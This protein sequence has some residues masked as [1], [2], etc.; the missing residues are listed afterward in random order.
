MLMKTTSF[1]LTSLSVSHLEWNHE[2]SAAHGHRKIG[3][4]HCRVRHFY[5][6][7]VLVPRASESTRVDRFWKKMYSKWNESNQCPLQTA[8][9]SLVCATEE[10]SSPSLSGIDGSAPSSNKSFMHG[11][12]LEWAAI[13]REHEQIRRKREKMIL[14]RRTTVFAHLRHVRLDSLRICS[15]GVSSIH[16]LY[17]LP[18]VIELIANAREKWNRGWADADVNN[19]ISYCIIWLVHIELFLE[20]FLH[21]LLVAILTEFIDRSRL[22]IRDHFVALDQQPTDT[23]SSFVR[24]LPERTYRRRFPSLLTD[25]IFDIVLSLDICHSF[26]VVFRCLRPWGRFEVVPSIPEPK[27]SEDDPFFSLKIILTIWLSLRSWS[28][29][30]E[31]CSRHPLWPA[32]KGIGRCWAI[33]SDTHLF[34]S[35]I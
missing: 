11:I 6:V 8:R 35:S 1:S 17:P 26:D 29:P 25:L 9:S 24:F 13:E 23:R 12:L 10:G 31:E 28:S 19:G 15:T 20:Y 22:A 14:Y 30:A 16:C 33:D 7:I 32:R 2:N 3:I 4:H 18:N 21:A 27:E 34:E 5:V